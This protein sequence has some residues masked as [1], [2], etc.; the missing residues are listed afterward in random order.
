M[1]IRH[2]NILYVSDLNVIGGVETYIYEM[3]KKYKDLDIAV[4]YRTGHPNQI[5]RLLK[6]CFV[7]QHKERDIFCKVAIINYD[8]KIIPYIKE[9][10][11]Y[12]VLHADYSH[13]KNRTH[14]PN[15]DRVQYI[16]ITKYICKSFE[17]ITGKKPILHYN[18]LS[19]EKSDKY[20]TLVSAT[21]LTEEKGKDRM[22]KLAEELDKQNIDYIWYIF[23]N[24]KEAIN[25]PNVIYMKPRLDVYRWIEKAD[26]IIQLSDTEAYC[27]T[28]NEALYRNIPVIITPFPY[29]DEIGIKDGENAYI[30]DFDCKNID[31]VVS[32][33]KDRLE[34]TFKTKE[35]KYEEIL[36]KGH[37]RFKEE[38]MKVK[39][40]CIRE[41]FDIELQRQVLNGEELI[42]SRKRA[43]ELLKNPYN[44]VELVEYIEEPKPEKAVKPKKKVT[45]R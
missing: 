10:K 26:Y 18:P 12:Q 17:E 3:V 45:K 14:M 2:D 5:K 16:G 4:V 8:T 9:G 15:D 6:Y 35:D 32:K 27:Y 42:V 41:Y 13:P 39:L 40:R 22:I 11:I 33:L 7:Y 21:R 44:I 23:T 36:Y 43:D 38:N 31:K 1:E 29:L 19:I 28:I 34:F 25:S 20:L 30:V 37:S 24:D